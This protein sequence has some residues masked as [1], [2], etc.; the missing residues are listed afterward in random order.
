MKTILI[1]SILL[2]SCVS[3][4]K[5]MDACL[6][7]TGDE[8]MVRFGIPQRKEPTDNGEVWVFSKYQQA[9]LTTGQVVAANEYKLFFLDSRKIVYAWR[10]SKEPVPIQQLNVNMY[11]R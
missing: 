7:M 4:R 6:G 8:L 2:F 11:I 3:T 9:M 5:Q 10:V 1:I